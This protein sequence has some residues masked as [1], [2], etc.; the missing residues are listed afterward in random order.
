MPLEHADRMSSPRELGGGREADDAGP[1]DRDVDVG[2]YW[3]S[4]RTVQTALNVPA[5]ALWL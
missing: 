3:T 1:D 4:T 2:R 5:T